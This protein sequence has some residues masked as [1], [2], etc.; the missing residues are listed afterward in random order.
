MGIPIHIVGNLTSDPELRYTQN[1]LPVAGFSVAVNERKF[2]RDKNEWTDG[3]TTFVRCSAWREMAEQVAASLT[4]G[5]RVMVSGKFDMKEYETKDGAKG[6]ALEM[7]VDE[8]GPSLRYA[9][10]VVTKAAQRSPQQGGAPQGYGQQTP[11]GYGQAQ[12]PQGW[13]AQQPQ[14]GPP[15]GWQQPQAP[16]GPPPGAWAQPGAY[17][18]DTPF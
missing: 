14:Q 16:Q 7:N 18:D 17:G 9:T 2:D 13:P 5:M 4:K 15:Q 1:G 12:Q 11:P 6:A 3:E 8:I 10:A